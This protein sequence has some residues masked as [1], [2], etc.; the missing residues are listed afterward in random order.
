M[1]V[2]LKTTRVRK[3]SLEDTQEGS[4]Q[5]Q[6]KAGSVLENAWVC[7]CLVPRPQ[8]F[9][10]S[11]PTPGRP[12]GIRHRNKLTPKAWERAVQKLAMPC[13]FRYF[14]FHI[15]YGMGG[16]SSW[17]EP[18]SFHVFIEIL[19]TVTFEFQFTESMKQKNLSSKNVK[20]VCPLDLCA[21]RGGVLINN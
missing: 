7:L 2:S 9:A 5:P 8:Y 6:G 13:G 16:K 3:F 11:G 14:L 10:Y 18:F 1:G 19:G 20:Y 4:E 21:F 12:S 15:H 17:K